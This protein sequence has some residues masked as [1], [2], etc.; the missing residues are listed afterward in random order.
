[1]INKDGEFSEIKQT[2]RS[3]VE[4]H[5]DTARWLLDEL[6]RA[7]TLAMCQQDRK[8]AW[9]TIDRVRAFLPLAGVIKISHLPQTH[10]AAQ[11]RHRMED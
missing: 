6:D 9:E 10:G 1:M 11:A 8:P 5:P 7:E 3:I 2:I 4:D